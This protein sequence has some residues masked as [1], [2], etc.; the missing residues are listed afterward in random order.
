[1]LIGVGSLTIFQVSPNYLID[2]FQLYA[3]SAVAVTTAMRSL[4]AGVFPLFTSPMFHKMGID[5][6][7]SVLGFVA[8]ALIPIPFLFDVY[9]FRIRARG[10]WSRPSTE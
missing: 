3:A 1:V 4:L 9:G 5:W 6:A 7:S 10:K 2:T 8:V